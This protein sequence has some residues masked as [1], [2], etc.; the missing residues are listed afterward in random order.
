MTKRSIA[1]AAAATSLLL[2][3]CQIKR[4]ESGAEATPTPSPTPAASET[5]T[6]TD[7]PTPTATAP[8]SIIRRDT[9]PAPAVDLP[10]EPLSATI[11]FGDGGYELSP[12][13]LKLLES[14]VKSDQVK[15]GWPITL[16][17]HTDAAGDDRG[18]LFASR[19]RAEAVAGW[20]VDHGIAEKRIEVIAMG[21]QNPVAPNANLD[22]TPNEAGRRK[23]RRVEVW[24]GPKG[25]QPGEEQPQE[26]KAV[27]N[28]G[29]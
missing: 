6:L 12:A 27:G 25:T 22:G 1:I 5:V 8:A 18:N 13:A 10:P 21:E 16:W 26:G 14:L 29:A 2:S 23:N 9:S 11:P 19:K 24:V 28:D 4:E 17:G 7:E 15:Q 3:G 20:L